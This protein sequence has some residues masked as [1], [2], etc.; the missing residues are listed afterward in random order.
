MDANFSFMSQRYL[1]TKEIFLYHQI[2]R[3]LKINKCFHSYLLNDKRYLKN[4]N[5]SEFRIKST[6]NTVIFVKIYIQI[7]V[8]CQKNRN[9]KISH[10][11][12]TDRDNSKIRKVL[13]SAYHQ[14]QAVEVS[15]KSANF[16]FARVKG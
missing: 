2:T 14:E 7:S 1:A 6:L 3:L 5:G 10:I 4:S 12:G 11:F 15:R 13:T 8:H 16:S 9:A